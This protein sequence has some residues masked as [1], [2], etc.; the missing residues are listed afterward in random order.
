ME[1]VVA[2]DSSPE[3]VFAQAIKSLP[4]SGRLWSV[5]ADY[6]ES[7]QASSSDTISAW[8][9]ASI[10]RVLLADA[11]PPIGFVSKFDSSD[12]NISSPRDL[13]PSRYLSYLSLSTPSLL[14]SRIDSLITRSPT[15]TLFFL[16]TILSVV[17]PSTKANK[18]FRTKVHERAV[19]HPEAGAKEWVDFAEELLKGGETAKSGEVVRRAG[20]SLK[21]GEKNEFER[22]WNE[23]V[24]LA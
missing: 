7:T 15:L 17:P 18:A 1:T 16:S 8:Y 9:E 12:D 10:E 19:G 5:H 6:V 22:R 20:R 3:P 23:V 13:L 24:E 14:V 21:G 11:V 4:F 2:L